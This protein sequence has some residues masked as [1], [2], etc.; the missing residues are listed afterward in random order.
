MKRVITAVVLVPVVLSLVFLAPRWLFA[1]AVAAV[2]ALAGW[3]Y[4][5]LAQKCSVRPPRIALVLALIALFAVNFEWPERTPAFFGVVCLCL[6]VY[7]T[8]LRPVT[9]VMA[10]AAA[11]IFLSLIHI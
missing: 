5:G 4:V 10:D 8:F 7:C 6:L 11:S 2:A 3:E 1:L 9:Q